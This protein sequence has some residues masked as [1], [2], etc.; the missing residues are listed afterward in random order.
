MD[1][2]SAGVTERQGF[3]SSVCERRDPQ[4]REWLLVRVRREFGEMPDLILTLAQAA[5]LFG[6]R[7]DICLRVLGAL[8]SEGWLCQTGERY[9]RR[10]SPH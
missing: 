3:P 5:R 4:T 6:I 9:A 10:M 1:R 8:A 7:K 2:T